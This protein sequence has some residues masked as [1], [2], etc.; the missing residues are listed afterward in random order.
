MISFDMRTI[1]FSFVLINILSTLIIFFLWKQYRMRYSGL[2]LLV[3]G[4]SLQ[5]VAY[6]LIFLRDSVSDWLSFGVGNSLSVAGIIIGLVGLAK[7]AGRRV[8]MIPDYIIF[9]LFVLASSWFVYRTPHS[10]ARYIILSSTYA[11]LFARGA[12]LMLF[13]TPQYMAGFT[14]FTGSVFSALS[15][16][17]VLKIA[18]IIIRGDKPA[19]YF[20]SDAFEAIVMV[21]YEMLIVL[22][23]FSISTMLSHNLLRDIKSEEEK[24]STIYQSTPNA[25]IL[26][27]YPEG[28]IIEVNDKFTEISGFEQSEVKGRTPVELNLWT[29][30]SERQEV[31]S[32]LEKS[33]RLSKKECTI[34]KKS[35]EPL[36]VMLSIRII[37]FR[38]SMLYISSI[39]D[40]T[41]RK[42]LQDQV[43]HE[44]NLLRTLLD[45]LPDPVSI[46]D[47]EGKYLLNNSAHLHVLGADTQEEVAGKSAYD[48]FPDED[49]SI[50]SADDDAVLKSG[51]S[52]IDKIEYAR[53]TE[54]GFPY[55]HMTSKIPI[56][57][58]SGVPVQLLTISHD[59]TE[60]KRS[61]DIL[62]ETDE[63][64]RSLLM[65][66]PFGMDVVDETGTL[67]FMGEKFRKKFGNDAIGKKCW[68]LYSDDGNQCA[69]CPLKNGISTGIT[70]NYEAHGILGGRIFEINHTGMIYHG[71]KAML[72]IFHDV[73]ERKKSESALIRSKEKA[74]ESDRLKTAFLHNIS[75]EIRT[76]M[77]AIVGFA[78]LLREPS[79]TAEE[80]D[81]YTEIITKSSNHLLSIVSDLI[82][83]SNVEAGRLQMSVHECN[84]I[85]ILDDLHAQF[86]GTAAGKGIEFL[87]ETPKKKISKLTTDCTKLIQIFTN[88][89]NNAFKFTER[90]RIEFG[91]TMKDTCIE[92]FVSDT[93]I[94][95]DEYAQV[96]IFDRFYQ[97]DNTVTRLHEGTGIG[98][99]I[100]KA[101]VE[102]LGGTIRV[103]SAPGKGSVFYFTLPYTVNNINKDLQI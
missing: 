18:D 31:I 68:E 47:A 3:T 28:R 5:F 11:I 8:S 86:W 23:T 103:C 15:L 27:S 51:K 32:E 60:R 36:T 80:R 57:D 34:R 59:I 66:I 21:I 96:K 102:L 69:G 63:F 99:S 84:L 13:A 83:I 97:V 20:Q 54:T 37:S 17:S 73:T 14:R 75:H 77:N 76:P 44:R 90:G 50:Y 93:G 42:R 7:Y 72:E 95:I 87:L 101:Y 22:L 49:A 56:K 6:I 1:I 61:E 79:I 100:S 33:G 19:D 74:E 30:E 52:I 92:F 46:K 89:L 55:W 62:R 67:M 38:N 78:N 39:N 40:I 2:G 12:W 58:D 88:L 71:K 45:H 64:N 41:E 91:Y 48:F 4:Y 16:L 65:T 70:Q 9:I 94:G 98:L 43:K 10:G 53:N 29:R 81:S 24:F 85:S 82:E 35:G 26:S 25:I